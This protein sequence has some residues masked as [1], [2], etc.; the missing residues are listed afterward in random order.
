[1]NTRRHVVKK[2]QIISHV[3][4]TKDI[5]NSEGKLLDEVKPILVLGEHKRANCSFNAVM[6]AERDNTLIPATITA[7]N[8]LMRFE[9]HRKV[10]L[11]N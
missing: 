5:R 9:K 8:T 2:Q 10:L 1:M 4:S 7:I 3:I 11:M 6:D